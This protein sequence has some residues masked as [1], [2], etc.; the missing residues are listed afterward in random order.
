MKRQRLAEKP[1]IARLRPQVGVSSL[2]VLALGCT[3]A[4]C[5]EAPYYDEPAPAAP[6]AYNVPASALRSPEELDEIFAPIALYPDALVAL[7]LPAATVSYDIVD[8]ADF[9]RRNGDPAQLDHQPWDESVK[10]LAHYPEIVQWMN[11]NLPWTQQAGQ[12]FLLQP[13][14]VMKSIQQ[15]RARALAAGTLR[16]TPQQQVIMDGTEIRIEPVQPDTIYV[17]R[18]DPDTV[19]EEQAPGEADW[20]TFGVGFPVGIWLNCD[21]DWDHHGIWVGD[22]EHNRDYRHPPWRDQDRN[23]DQGHDRDRRPPAGHA[24]QPKPGQHREPPHT[25]DRTR[26]PIDHPRPIA[27]A[28]APRSQPSSPP[29]APDHRRENPPAN[30]RPDPRGYAAPPAVNH[31]PPAAARPA[32]PPTSVFG[33]YSRGS[34]ARDASQRGQSSRQQV[35]SAPA[36]HSN[37]PAARSEP[38]SNDRSGNRRQ[39]N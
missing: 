33:G 21:L 3:L 5:V 10:S 37:P 11:Q 32:A 22:W 8:A 16:N 38:A 15:L 34:D 26:P 19:Y 9:L 17:P 30:V 13:A 1:V 24:W 29:P 35:Q 25:P 20:I 27:G 4:G 6:P 18:Y 31:G 28:P 12:A 23:R 14:D 39:P 36:A 2:T 7:I